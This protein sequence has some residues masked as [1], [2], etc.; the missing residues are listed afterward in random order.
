MIKNRMVIIVSALFLNALLITC[1]VS[2]EEIKLTTIIPS[3]DTVR[4]QSG[5]AIGATSWFA[6][7][8]WAKNFNWNYSSVALPPIRNN[9]AFGTLA[10]GGKIGI[11][12][13]DPCTLLE[14]FD[15]DTYYPTDN[16]YPPNLS[17]ARQA[18]CITKDY[19]CTSGFSGGIVWRR[20]SYDGSLLSDFTEAG[21][22]DYLQSYGGN[23]YTSLIF[24]ASGYSSGSSSPT[25]KNTGL[26][27]RG[28]GQ[29]EIG[30]TPYTSHPMVN[31]SPILYVNGDIYATGKITTGGTITAGTSFTTPGIGAITEISDMRLKKNVEILP[32][33][34]LDRL[35]KLRGVSFEW[36]MDEF[37]DMK[38]PAGKHIGMIAQ[39]VEKEYPELV[40]TDSKGYKSIQ[41]DKFTAV[42]LEGIKE[43]K[44]QNDALKAAND[45]LE[46][47]VSA[48]EKK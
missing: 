33:D 40:N 10:V 31:G 16:Y 13:Y 35:L 41:Y 12:T 45:A 14:I 9:A 32:F 6:S 38:L 24:G 15:P 23:T 42:L 26:I 27:L 1:L 47:R 25:V 34:T 20:G 48:L 7:N 11:G 18:I 46:K 36:R 21:I 5:V 2:A 39:E 22:W 17:G 30:G 29:V 28:D 4:T 44:A 19:G 43:L 8:N 3:S 37:K